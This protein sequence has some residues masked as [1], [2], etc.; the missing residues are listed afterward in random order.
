MAE[1]KAFGTYVRRGHKN[2]LLA[3]LQQ[4]QLEE[5][6]ELTEMESFFDPQPEDRENLL[7]FKEKRTRE[8]IEEYY[9]GED[10]V[11]EFLV[12]LCRMAS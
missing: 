5:A 11:D 10:V 12:A 7:A 9:D 8:V 1:Q 4:A 2:A 6:E 3:E